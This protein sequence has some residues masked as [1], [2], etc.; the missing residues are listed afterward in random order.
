MKA[1][2]S[3]FRVGR[4]KRTRQASSR[5][6]NRKEN[7][8]GAKLPGT[9]TVRLLYCAE[10]AGAG[11]YQAMAHHYRGRPQVS[12]LLRVCGYQEAVRAN[13]FRQFYRKRHGKNLAGGKVFFCLGKSAAACLRW[14]PLKQKIRIIHAVE[15][16]SAQNLNA[17]LAHGEERSWNRILER[18]MPDNTLHEGLSEAVCL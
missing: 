9:A 3:I 4:D 14:L 8:R 1:L 10:M 6:D 13:L 15:T 17:V 2:S 18:N 5:A 7:Q 16:R 11:M 12:R